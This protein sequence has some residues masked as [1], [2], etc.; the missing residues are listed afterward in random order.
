MNHLDISV[1]RFSGD[2]GTLLQ[3]CENLAILDVSGDQVSGEIPDNIGKKKKLKF[4]LLSDYQFHSRIPVSLV[5]D[6]CLGL[7]NLDLSWNNLMG[8]LPLE[9]VCVLR[10]WRPL[11]SPSKT[12]QA[13]SLFL[14][15][16]KMK[17]LKKIDLSVNNFVGGLHDSFSELSIL[18]TLDLRYNDM[19]G[20]IAPSICR[21][22]KLR[23]L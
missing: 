6:L 10:C 4:I 23:E 3:L 16:C 20:K 17:R 21:G 7:V 11:A 19:I 14:R 18:E 13:S 1:N 9:L 12:S 8:S 2:L 15:C 22:S 5:G